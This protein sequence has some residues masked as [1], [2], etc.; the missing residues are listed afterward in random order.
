MALDCWRYID[1]D[2]VSASFGLAADEWM[3]CRREGPPCLRLYTYRSHCVLIGRYQRL[4]AEANVGA[5]RALGVELN[6]RPTGGGTIL[7]G[8]DQLGVALTIPASARAGFPRAT[9]DLFPHL[10]EGLITALRELGVAASFHRKND[11]EVAG[12]KIAGLGIFAAPSGGLLFHASLVVD[13]DVAFM[14]QVLHTPFEKLADKAVATVAERMTTLRREAGRPVTVDEVRDRIRAGYA[15]AFGVVLEEAVWT[16]EESEDICALEE[17]KY[18]SAAWLD[19]PGL[20][21]DAGGRS[22]HKAAG[23]LVEVA[24]TL[25]GDLIS[26][27][28]LTGDFFAG[29]G[30]VASLE[31]SLRRTAVEPV[32]IRTAVDRAYAE[33]AR[34]EGVPPD[35]LATA[36][37]EAAAD[38]AARRATGQPYGCFVNP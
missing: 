20:V 9:R 31:R 19:Q 12:R 5:C 22:R 28:T 16:L 27:C 10:A 6:R 17:A 35:L 8:A 30:Q 11:L 15:E 23:G 37:L 3:A 18:R 2:G 25:R 7:M 34:L 24:L 1:E 33:G 36:V 14:L 26:Q 29:D 32:A 4:E 13:L 21:P 38:A